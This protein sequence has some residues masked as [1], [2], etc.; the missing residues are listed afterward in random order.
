MSKSRRTFPQNLQTHYDCCNL[1]PR[2][3]GADRTRGR[4]GFCGQG[5][6]LRLAW[7]GIHCGEEPP[8]TAQ[9]GSGTVFFTG[10]TLKCSFCQNHQ[11][12]HEGLGAEVSTDT[13]A[14]IFLDLQKQGAEN[15]NLV[16]ATP[17]IPSIIDSVRLAQKRGLSVP[18]L[19][20][21]SGYESGESLEL[22]DSFVDIY[23]PDLKTLDPVLSDRLFAAPDYPEVARIALIR[24][25][26]STEAV[27]E[28]DKLQRGV[29][30]RHLVLPGE[31]ESTK[32]VLQWYRE[33]LYGRALLSLMFQYTPVSHG[34][35]VPAHPRP[36][37]SFGRESGGATPSS[38]NTPI[39]L[40]NRRVKRNEYDLVFKWL[41]ELKIEEGFVQEFA[42]DEAWLPDFSRLNPFAADLSRAVWHYHEGF[43]E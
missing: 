13:L 42:S 17:F 29:M 33:N 5:Q 16:T 38:S 39:P 8:V 36:S 15:I 30:V 18:I 7:A 3:C 1:C 32:E 26:E 35:P 21:T 28:G 34:Q 22:L 37:A 14:M 20:N 25:T 12:S 40:S 11:I 19:W 43:V 9:K 2:R 6:A 31:L 27:F 4:R 23:L 41:E 10:C 24:M